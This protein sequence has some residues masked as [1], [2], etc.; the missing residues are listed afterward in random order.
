MNE[1][2]IPA[3]E[4]L[5]SLVTPSSSSTQSMVSAR[6]LLLESLDERDHVEN[7]TQCV[8]IEVGREGAGCLYR[9][10]RGGCYLSWPVE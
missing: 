5:S 7:Q 3:S 10:H 8:G 2:T 6:P 1:W 4:E 9:Y